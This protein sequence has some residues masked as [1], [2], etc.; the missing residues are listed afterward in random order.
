MPK[1]KKRILITLLTFDGRGLPKIIKIGLKIVIELP[2]IQN[3]GSINNAHSL[4]LST[5]H[6]LSYC[7]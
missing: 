6:M 7:V 5:G 1:S 3:I 2:I 4:G